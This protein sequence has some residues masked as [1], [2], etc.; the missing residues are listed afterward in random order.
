MRKRKYP[1]KSRNK[2]KIYSIIFANHGKMKNTI[3]SEKTENEIYKRFNN[4]LKENKK[5]VFPVRYNNLEHV[6]KPSEYEIIIL[7]CRDEFESKENKVRDDSG[8]FITYKTTSD[9]WIVIDRAPYDVEETFW[10][11]GFHPMLQ[12]KNFEWIFENFILKDSKNKYMFKSVQIYNN[13]VLFDCNGKLEMVMCKNKNDSVRL[14]NQ[15]E[16]YAIKAKCKYCLFMGDIANSKHKRD[17]IQR[18]MDLT[19]WNAQKVK[20]LSTRD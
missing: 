3:C 17:W 11:Y 7:K 1:R 19:H 20:R 8:E 10:V 15:L 13:K 14:Y 2:V 6:M 9:D 12:R 4:L 18:I 5:I 16:Q